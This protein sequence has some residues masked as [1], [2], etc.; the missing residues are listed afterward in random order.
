M[1]DVGE[2]RRKASGEQGG[3]DDQVAFPQNVTSNYV[4]E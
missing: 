2:N 1:T 4:I 3:H